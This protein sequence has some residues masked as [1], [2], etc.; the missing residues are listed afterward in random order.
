MTK[1]SVVPCETSNIVSID[2]SK[3]VSP[4]FVSPL[5]NNMK[6]SPDEKPKEPLKAVD[7]MIRRGTNLIQIKKQENSLEGKKTSDFEIMR[8]NSGIKSQ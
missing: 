3:K 2:F 6:L 1:G 4:R 7:M 5:E 8:R